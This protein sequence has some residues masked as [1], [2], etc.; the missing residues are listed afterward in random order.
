MTPAT[1]RSRRSAGAILA[2]LSPLL[3]LPAS[4]LGWHDGNTDSHPFVRLEAAAGAG[5]LVPLFNSGEVFDSVTFQ[6]IPDGLGVVP[7]PGGTGWIDIYVAHEESHVPFGVTATSVFADIQDSSV[8]RVR[9]DVA[10]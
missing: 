7:G 10:T 4:T 5:Q 1:G 2:A 6:G 8:T 3:T 9:M